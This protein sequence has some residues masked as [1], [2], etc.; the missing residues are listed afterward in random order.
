MS[1]GG[2]RPEGADDA[3]TSLAVN[4]ASQWAALAPEARNPDPAQPL[5]PDAVTAASL[6]AQLSQL[7]RLRA[8]LTDHFDDANLPRTRPGDASA[9]A[10]AVAW[11]V[12]QPDGAAMLAN[13][14]T[15]PVQELDDLVAAPPAAPMGISQDQADALLAAGLADPGDA[16]TGLAAAAGIDAAG[17]A[18]L[19]A[20]GARELDRQGI[21]ADAGV[22]VLAPLR[23]E[24]RFLP[25]AGERTRWLLRLRVLPDEF[26]FDRRPA[27]PTSAELKALEQALN[28]S[29][30]TPPVDE[31]AAFGELA[32]ALGAPRA[33][34]L[35]RTV[36]VAR[37][38]DHVTPAASVAVDP[39][40]ASQPALQLPAG[41]PPE[42]QVVLVRAGSPPETAATLTLDRAAIAAEIDLGRFDAA[43]LDAGMLPRL[44]WTSYARAQEVGLA[45]DIE[46]GL[47]PPQLEA[48]IVVGLGDGPPDELVQAHAAGGRLAVLAPGTPTN[49]VQGEPTTELGRDAAAWAPLASATGLDQRATGAVFRALTGSATPSAPLLG[50][51]LDFRNPGARLVA[52]LWA[53]LW[54]RALR[55]VA[56]ALPELEDAFSAWAQRLLAPE[57]PYPAIRVGDQPYGLLPATSL[58][59]WVAHATDPEGERQI[60]A[61]ATAWRAEAANAAEA[62]GTVDGADPERLLALLGAYAPSQRWASRAIGSI[63]EV[64][65]RR[66]L[67][68]LAPGGPTEWDDEKAKALTGAAEPW[69]AIGPVGWPRE[70]GHVMHPPIDPHPDRILRKLVTEDAQLL[71]EGDQSP[72]QLLGELIRETLLV[73][74]ARVGL[75]VERA[76]TGATDPLPI[77]L[78]DPGEFLNLVTGGSNAAVSALV[79]PASPPD[80][81]AA[82]QRFRA[83]EA[84]TRDLVWHI[85]SDDAAAR[86]RLTAALFATLDAASHRVDPWTVGIADRRLRRLTAAGAPFRL[87]AYGWVDRPGAFAVDPRS[88]LA[89]G[90]TAA[91]VLH[92]PS[93]SQ[94]LTAAL[95]RDG[96]MRQPADA[97][98]DLAIDSEKVRGAIRL[99]ERVRSGVHPYEVLGLEIEARVGNWDDVRKLR[100]TFALVDVNPERRPCDGAA[101]LR[102]VFDGGGA[103]PAGLTVNLAQTLAPVRAAVDSY[104]DLLLVDGVQ[105][106][107]DGQGSVGR[108]AMEAGAGL[109]PPAEL[110]ALRTPRASSRVRVSVWALLPPADAG[111]DD[112][113]VV[114]ADPA[115]TLVVRNELGDPST[116]SWS[117]GGIDVSAA[118]LGWAPLELLLLDRAA[119]VSLLRAAAGAP[120]DAT[121]TS[122]G[123]D[124]RLAAGQRLLSLIGASDQ[125]PLVPN[126][127]SAGAAPVA[128]TGLQVAVAANLYARLGVLVARARALVGAG[129]TA[130]DLVRWG[131]A[132]PGEMLDPAA[133]A[134]AS[135]ALAARADAAAAVPANAGS[136]ALR[137]GIRALVGRPQLPVVAVVDRPLLP[138][139]KLADTDPDGRP[140]TDRTWLEVV[141]AVRPRLEQ[142][143]AR[144]LDSGRSPWPV[145]VAAGDGSGDPWSVAAAV[146]SAPAVVVAYGL[147]VTSGGLQVGV[148]PL[149]A[150]IDAV[151]SRRQATTA[152]FG[153]NGPNAQPP[154]AILL[155][156]PPD[157]GRRMTAD[158]LVATIQETRLSL[159][160]R[161]ALPG[162]V[163]ASGVPAPPGALPAS[164]FDSPLATPSVIVGH[165]VRPE[166]VKERWP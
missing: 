68:G 33:A 104:A 123:G 109:G 147:G 152:A 165:E 26:S 41:L 31:A 7:A 155:A 8:R 137:T 115:L 101:V 29:S 151:P 82:G 117:V 134:T 105:A 111:A 54:G 37:V 166:D 157:L 85:P 49:T 126:P 93:A 150:W 116:W 77:Q 11:V 131:L 79:N 153:F 81:R 18:A 25:P 5:P 94:A 34:W 40:P 78:A 143:L 91:G 102:A 69:Q 13:L 110:R 125:T 160:A 156:V 84:A 100:Q 130:A 73:S 162:D 6:L 50:G 46:L 163:P 36:P 9:D 56:G 62:A 17:L 16:L 58:D 145:A 44:W 38:G 3:V 24:T 142:L 14:A 99:A 22:E 124:E 113:P 136:E 140:V 20:T 146:G 161:A 30:R 88:T 107:V 12:A 35:M 53:A 148:A 52:G 63:A 83:Q 57:G 144:E 158:D 55:D 71:I 61:W 97:R 92:A 128:P 1:D 112:P 138:A 74:R 10:A 132:S 90:P 87:G 4:L 154:Q 43:S 86:E 64:R 28:A 119:L 47:T 39:D 45:A 67:A 72:L 98:W 120:A 75:A 129:P 149:D 66:A 2:W 127:D 135:Q 121:V 103:L 159:R 21:G 32:D 51:D 76:P 89:P 95:L 118:S 42:L 23:L 19:R 106:L 15:D 164:R 133:V 65:A 122:T 108:A 59:R 139:L 141:A 48:I 96:A 70:L 27:P 60:R 80:D 114:A